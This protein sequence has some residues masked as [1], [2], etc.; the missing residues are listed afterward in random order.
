MENN[1]SIDDDFIN[2]AR[3][4]LK[5]AEAN[6]LTI[7]QQGDNV[8]I[9]LINN[10]FRAIHSLKG[11]ASFMS[12]QN[13][14]RLSHAMETILGKMREG[15]L[16]PEKKLIDALL[17]GVDQLK[18]LIDDT[19]N[20]D[21]VSIQPIY[22]R[23]A[24]LLPN[25]EL[26][27]QGNTEPKPSGDE[28]KNSEAVTAQESPPQE[29]DT[30]GKPQTGPVENENKPQTDYELPDTGGS[31]FN[32]PKGEAASGAVAVDKPRDREIAEAS[33]DKPEENIKPLQTA[34]IPR[35]Q[36]V[37]KNKKDNQKKREIKNETIRVDVS[38][39][40]KLM[41]VAGELVLVRNQ[42]LH[43]FAKADAEVKSVVHHLNLVTN[44]LQEGLMRT[45]MQPIKN[46][47]DAIP[48]I[49]RTLS[50]DLKK[51][52]KVNISGNEVEL[53]KTILEAL[54]DPLTHLIRNC[55]DHGVELPDDRAKQGKPAAGNIW[56]RAFHEG[57]QVMVE[58]K[59]DG[60]GINVERIKAKALKATFRTADELDSMSN[61][62]LYQ[63]I[64]HPGF[65]TAEVV[66]DVSGRGVGMD[67]VK[68]SI[69]KLSG[70][71]DIDS[72]PGKGTTMML[73][74]PLTLAIIH[75]LIVKVG[76]DHF[77]IP[78]INIEE[79]VDLYDEEVLNCIEYTGDSETYRLRNSILPLVRLKDV[80]SS[81]NKLTKND[82]IRIAQNNRAVSENNQINC[83]KQETPSKAPAKQRKNIHSLNFAV[84]KAG[85]ERYGLIVDEI[86]GAEEIVI[87]PIHPLLN[88]LRCY[89]GTTVMGDGR[90]VLILDT[91]GMAEHA[92]AL[93]NSNDTGLSSQEQKNIEFARE[94]QSFLLF[95]NGTFEQFAIALPLIRR[96]EEFKLSDIQ[97]IGPR[98]FL[99]VNGES[100]LV[101]RL[102]KYLNV[103][104]CDEQEDMALILPKYARNPYG[105][106]VSKI[107]G[108]ETTVAQLNTETYTET[109]LLGTAIING[110]ITMFPDI[111]RL[112][113]TAEPDWFKNIEKNFS[114]PET[115]KHVLLVE[116][117]SF[118]R[119]LVKG[120]LEALKYEVVA[121]ENG[122][123]GLECL[124]KEH[125][126][127]IISDIE[128]PV[129][130]GLKFIENVRAG[131]FQSKLPALA[132]SSLDSGKSMERAI[133][134]GFDAYEI[135]IDQQKLLYKVA[136]LIKE[137]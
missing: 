120:Y 38:L 87:K 89:S 7:E 72:T 112:I 41:T 14:T 58:I 136:E 132:L 108:I 12:L 29:S 5:C 133:Q 84:V 64:F 99:T 106:L 80:I 25:D 13:V 1:S 77:A 49:V 92:G 97:R 91:L 68:S 78:Q 31:I 21:D 93:F 102:D 57:G 37:L 104:A 121:A 39:L 98:E 123:I 23:L 90:V 74:L 62:E 6:F 18:Q 30:A 60:A 105:I 51:K 107:F 54:S 15:E 66:T 118:F 110:Q 101:I 42:Q 86:L 130:D 43:M 17:D 20:S 131:K 103:S 16:K 52:I 8:D 82:R 24:N 4:Y 128:M 32:A 56:V 35:E 127:L 96:I 19:T 85:A 135:K 28:T 11:S 22:V 76:D 125:F 95:K 79:L 53:D 134:S 9:G 119:Q 69:E 63:L 115:K 65:S 34:D 124:Q 26:A 27:P 61:K 114:A 46:V 44:E 50:L 117:C 126:D 45:R 116:D 33:P 55:C 113:K 2:E 81:P 71:I 75:S 70:S 40:N 10:I 94:K 100:T 129:M 122:K 59:D 137:T 88:D 3:E 109:C 47:F 111:N 48:R 67:V 83:L 36:P 73:R